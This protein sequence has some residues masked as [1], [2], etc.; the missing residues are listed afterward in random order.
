MVEPAANAAEDDAETSPTRA[1]TE[2]LLGALAF[3]E[4]HIDQ[5]LVHLLEAEKANPRLARLHNQLG[6][7]YLRRRRWSDAERAFRKAVAIDGDNARAFHGLSVALLRQDKAV[8]AAEL[9]LRAVGLKHFFPGAHFQLGK[10]L[11]RL[12]W[13]ERAAQAFETGLTMRPN[14][15]VAHRY[16]ARLY[17]RLG[18]GEKAR[19]HRQAIATRRSEAATAPAAD[20][21]HG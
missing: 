15:A 13:P 16:L 1:R 12:N 14:A 8:E 5:A 3:E 19:A 11:T 20:A 6:E 18:Q 7:V 21:H 10:V 9:A 2:M 17:G 4:G